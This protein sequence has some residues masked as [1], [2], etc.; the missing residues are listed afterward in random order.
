MIRP[1]WTFMSLPELSHLNKEQRRK[2]IDNY[3]PSAEFPIIVKCGVFAI[4]G[5]TVFTSIVFGLIERHAIMLGNPFDLFVL[6]TS[7]VSVF[8]V[9]YQ[10]YLQAVRASLRN[11]LKQALRGEKVPMC[12]DCGYNLEVSTDDRCPECGARVRVPRSDS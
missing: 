4:F 10:V 11:Y 3:A 6:S 1:Y 8:I 5:G 2:L 12:L 7:I 9:A